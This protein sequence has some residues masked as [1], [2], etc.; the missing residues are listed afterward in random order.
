MKFNKEEILFN[1]ESPID[2]LRKESLIKIV[3]SKDTSFLPY[4]LK[5]ETND[6]NSE[7]RFYAKKS[8][9]FL[10][11]KKEMFSNNNDQTFVLDEDDEQIID[12]SAMNS[13]NISAENVK[14]FFETKSSLEKRN[15]VSKIISEKRKEFLPFIIKQLP[16]EKDQIIRAAII[17]AVGIFKETR[18]LNLI[19]KG[20][21]SRSEAVRNASIISLQNL[22]DKND[23]LNS[24]KHLVN[25]KSPK[26][27]AAAVIHLKDITSI[28]IFASLKELCYSDDI[29]AR[30]Q[31]LYACS[32]IKTKKIV[33]LVQ[34]LCNDLNS[35]ISETAKDILDSFPESIK[36]QDSFLFEE[37]ESES[38]DH[39]FQIEEELDNNKMYEEFAEFFKTLSSQISSSKLKILNNN[40]IKTFNTKIT[41][42][43]KKDKEKYYKEFYEH[44]EQLGY[45]HENKEL[46]KYAE[47]I[48]KCFENKEPV[49]LE[50]ILDIITVTKKY[51]EKEPISDSSTE[52]NTNNSSPP[53]ITKESTE[54]YYTF[55][56]EKYGPF[57]Q[58]KI[59]NFLEVGTINSE[60]LVWNKSLTE[61]IELKNTHFKKNLEEITKKEIG[62]SKEISY[63]NIPI[64]VRNNLR[65]NEKV[66]AISER[67]FWCY[68]DEFIKYALIF[69]IFMLPVLLD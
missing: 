52:K 32:S 6:P 5:M 67:S 28:D 34:Q 66:L 58:D 3:K 19:K 40:I 63:E 29:N 62:L 38:N 43:L 21:S 68:F 13:M 45:S 18:F 17:R 22:T 11:N 44:V 46:Q 48:V 37:E 42:E 56:D 54:W 53:P 49:N 47:Y 60:T 59:K 2:E 64:A 4:I 31:A 12:Y 69:I 27:R 35:Q 51:V 15:L 24:I 41:D 1:L 55:D 20:L 61:W 57:T 10:Q 23:F 16:V 25:D 9:E 14:K 33:P 30:L 7:L 39:L 36:K 65:I 26:V 8:A 50:K